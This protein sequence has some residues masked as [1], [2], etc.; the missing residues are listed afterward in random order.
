MIDPPFRPV[1]AELPSVRSLVRH[2]AFYLPDPLQ[3]RDPL[4]RRG[5]ELLAQRLGI[6]GDEFR[7]VPRPADF[8]VKGLQ[9]CAGDRWI[10]AC[11][12][13]RLL[14]GIDVFTQAFC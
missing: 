5:F 6:V 2:L 4:A 12:Q 3:R 8:D 11:P 13:M 10:A 14:F 1:I 7:P 9:P